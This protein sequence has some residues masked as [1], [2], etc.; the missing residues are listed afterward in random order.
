VISSSSSSS[1]SMRSSSPL[2][3]GHGRARHGPTDRP[4]LPDPAQPGCPTAPSPAV[5]R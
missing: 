3:L 4:I 2:V 1:L 5:G